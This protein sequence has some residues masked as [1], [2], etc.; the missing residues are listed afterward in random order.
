MIHTI[1]NIKWV[2]A[3]SLV[4]ILLG[5]LTFFTFIN[6]GF[7]ELNEFNLQILLLFDLVLLTLFFALII[8]NF[9][10]I[11]KWPLSSISKKLNKKKISSGEPINISQDSELRQIVM[12]EETVLVDFWAEW[13]G[14]CLLMNKTIT[15]IAQEY[16]GKVI[17]VKVDVSL[18]STLSKLY[19]VKGLPTVIV[20]KGGD[21]IARKSGSLT[22]NQLSELVV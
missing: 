21:E 22:K 19:K 13:C 2:R 9:I 14:P 20:F 5:V 3:T 15:N 10:A 1:K 6:K 12:E 11:T 17:V 18:N 8:T 4:C 7:V 16:E